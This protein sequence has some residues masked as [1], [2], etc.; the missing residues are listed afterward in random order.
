MS[1]RPYTAFENTATF[2]EWL[3][4]LPEQTV[5]IDD[6]MVE[7]AT[8]RVIFP[9]EA[10]V[11]DKAQ[12]SVFENAKVSP[13][14]KLELLK[15]YVRYWLNKHDKLVVRCT[16]NSFNSAVRSVREWRQDR[17][18]HVHEDLDRLV[19]HAIAY[20]EGRIAAVKGALDSTRK[21]IEE[22]LLMLDAVTLEQPQ[23][24][25]N[26][27]VHLR[28]ET[29]ARRAMYFSGVD[30]LVLDVMRFLHAKVGPDLVS[31]QDLMGDTPTGHLASAIKALH[32]SLIY[33]S[34]RY[35]DVVG[36]ARRCVLLMRRH[37]LE[38]GDCDAFVAHIDQYKEDLTSAR[39]SVSGLED[40]AV[41]AEGAGSPSLAGAKRPRSP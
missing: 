17:Q 36:S 41:R 21:R 16:R 15:D 28:I 29:I 27:D 37:C 24:L 8:R 31:V 14:E 38:H 1:T 10:E 13:S 25:Y 4:K 2:G 22:M 40:S 19:E 9:G 32:C 33:V 26:L 3:Q 7:S 18:A 20:F 35:W 5:H 34:D 23:S 6:E 39:A 12:S 11:R 30:T